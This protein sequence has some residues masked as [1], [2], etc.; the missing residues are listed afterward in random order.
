MVMALE[1]VL[2]MNK[3]DRGSTKLNCIAVKANQWVDE[4][5]AV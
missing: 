3:W 5:M 2:V 4:K 1:V